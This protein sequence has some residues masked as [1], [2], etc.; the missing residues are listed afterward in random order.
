MERRIELA[1]AHVNRCHMGRALLQKHLGEA[2]GRCANIKAIQSLDGDIEEIDSAFEL[3]RRTG[4]IDPRL[5]KN[6]NAAFGTGVLRG[7]GRHDAING[8]GPA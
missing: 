3:E 6:F 5:I 8:H 1:M 7:L 2:S 4:N